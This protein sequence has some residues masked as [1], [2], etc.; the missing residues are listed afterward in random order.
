MISHKGVAMLLPKTLS[1]VPI[2]LNLAVPLFALDPRTGE[3]F[4]AQIYPPSGLSVKKSR[5]VPR[6]DPKDPKA[7]PLIRDG[8]FT[9]WAQW[10]YHLGSD[11]KHFKAWW[12][13]FWTDAKNWPKC[14]TPVYKGTG[15]INQGHRIV[16]FLGRVHDLIQKDPEIDPEVKR[17]FMSDAWREEAEKIIAADIDERGW[18]K[19]GSNEACMAQIF[20]FL[21]TK[22][23]AMRLHVDRVYTL[24]RAQNLVC[25]LLTEPWILRAQDEY[26]DPPNRDY[27]ENMGPQKGGLDSDIRIVKD[28]KVLYSGGMFIGWKDQPSLHGTWDGLTILNSLFKHYPDPDPNSP[29][30]IFYKWNKLPAEKKEIARKAI[31][32]CSRR[33]WLDWQEN[34]GRTWCWVRDGE[35]TEDD[36]RPSEAPFLLAYDGYGD[37]QVC[38]ARMCWEEMFGNPMRNTND[39]VQALLA[40]AHGR[41]HTN[42]KT[43]MGQQVPGRYD[44]DAEAQK[45]RLQ[46]DEA[47]HKTT[48]DKPSQ[49]EAK[50]DPK[51][52]KKGTE[53]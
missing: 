19:H 44:F 10:F 20:H 29:K 18:L 23:G 21:R 49:E 3:G 33:L 38:W 22:F 42:L 6:P 32:L 5:I 45:K 12:D 8:K 16:A 2:A 46:E 47:R 24:E 11:P 41:I 15:A 34:K 53:E 13:N 30:S 36:S 37:N 39:G 26:L 40:I 52:A 4:K 7:F 51:K 50:P 14:E 48:A 31:L 25:T 35:P 43:L 17:A 27:L 28:G 9:D 1:L